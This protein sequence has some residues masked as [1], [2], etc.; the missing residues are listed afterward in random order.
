[1]TLF[2][3]TGG[4]AQS[5]VTLVDSSPLDVFILPD[6]ENRF[7]VTGRAD[8]NQPEQ[9]LAV[10]MDHRSATHTIPITY[11]DGYSLLFSGRFRSAVPGKRR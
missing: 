4:K 6:Y 11:A 8:N 3:V 5:P 2:R 1:M 10:P 9:L 7:V